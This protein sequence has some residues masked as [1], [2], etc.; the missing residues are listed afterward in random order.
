MPRHSGADVQAAK[1][2]AR[3]EADVMAVVEM[4]AALLNTVEKRRWSPRLQSVA[5]W[6]VSV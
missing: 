1:Q 4:V 3:S 5:P 6:K 2:A